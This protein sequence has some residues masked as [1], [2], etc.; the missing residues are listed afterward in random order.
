MLY[1][2]NDQQCFPYWPSCVRGYIDHV[3]YVARVRLHERALRD[4]VARDVRALT[5]ILCNI[6]LCNLLLI[7]YNY[8][9][10]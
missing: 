6:I 2:F 7:L 3:C 5:I 4:H 9:V 10:Y 1:I 8:I